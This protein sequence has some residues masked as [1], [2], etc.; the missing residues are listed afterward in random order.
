MPEVAVERN[1][2]I[3]WKWK[4]AKSVCR[5]RP[6]LKIPREISGYPLPI[7]AGT[8]TAKTAP[9]AQSVIRKNKAGI[10]CGLDIIHR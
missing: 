4:M 6:D 5:L 1:A 10:A 8:V 2:G 9:C 3:P 7:S